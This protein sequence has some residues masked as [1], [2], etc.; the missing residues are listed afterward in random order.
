MGFT[1]IGATKMQ[2]I[3]LKGN[4]NQLHME[5]LNSAIEA[6]ANAQAALENCLV[7]GTKIELKPQHRFERRPHI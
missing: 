4:R 6:L 2:R 1:L 3:S 7:L 5:Q